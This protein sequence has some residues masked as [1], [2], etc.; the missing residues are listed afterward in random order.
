MSVPKRLSERDAPR[1]ADSRIAWGS[2][3]AA[4]MLR[5]LDIPYIAL[6]PGASYRGRAVGSAYVDAS[7][8]SFHAVK[9]ITS[10]EGGMV[11]TVEIRTDASES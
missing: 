1:E 9:I 8:F 4:Q 6:N 5:R 3:V 2:D 11:V 10:A 7:V